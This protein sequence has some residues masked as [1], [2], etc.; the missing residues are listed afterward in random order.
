VSQ[1][2][3][4]PSASAA[5]DASTRL[6]SLKVSP[7]PAGALVLGRVIGA[8]GV[9]GA[10]KVDPFSDDPSNLVKLGHCWLRFRQA[11]YAVTVTAGRKQMDTAIL[12]IEGIA[13]RE[14]A[15]SLAGAEILAERVQLSRTA[16]DE[17]YWVDLIG[18]SVLTAS[19]VVLGTVSS[20]IS[21][22]AHD[23]LEIT[24]PPTESRPA[25]LIPFVNAYTLR[26]DI[27]AKQIEVDWDPDWE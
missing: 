2:K 18:C 10:L 1:P 3:G 25:R 13:V 5:A 22:G 6:H 24:P 11:T 15:A 16:S 7:A 26:V 4:S 12:E 20:L 14:L 19:G 9:H 27:A 17:Y 23:V 21:T 8:Y